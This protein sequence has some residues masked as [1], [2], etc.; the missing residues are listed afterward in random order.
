M[1]WWWAFG[2]WCHLV[3]GAM[4]HSVICG[5]AAIKNMLV[6]AANVS[7]WRRQWAAAKSCGLAATKSPIKLST[8]TRIMNIHTQDVNIYAFRT[9]TIHLNMVPKIDRCSASA[10]LLAFCI[11]DRAALPSP[12]SL[13][14]VRVSLR[15]K[16]GLPELPTTRN[17]P[18]EIITWRLKSIVDLLYVL[19]S[20][21]DFRTCE[22][23]AHDE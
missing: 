7:L 12:S 13:S 5:K 17:C 22:F 16:D 15:N 21:A 11:T 2:Y 9:S 3:C 14:F 1:S 23:D 10:T 19:R 6:A 4:R 8:Y 20:V 18:R